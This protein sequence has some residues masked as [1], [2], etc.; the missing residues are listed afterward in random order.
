M[1]DADYIYAVACIR[2]KEKTLLTDADIQSMVGMK[3]EKE[4]LSYLTEKGWGDGSVGSDMETVLAT[5]EE[6]Q[7][8]LLRT[9]GVNSEIIDVLFIQELYHNL[10]AAIKEV[11]TGLDD[12]MA[13]Y[14]HDK[15]GKDQMLS[16]I[17][18]KDFE[19]LPEYMRKIAEEALDFMLTTRDGQR[20]DMM[21]DRACLDATIESAKLTKDRF[22][23]E[24]AETKVLMADIK[25]AVRTADTR[26]PLSVIEEALAPVGKLDTKK[27]AVAA[28]TNR[29]S[30]Y[31]FLER[32]GY[33]DAVEALK[34]SFS[35]FEKWC[36]D[37]VMGTLMNQ[38]T[39]IQSSGPIV[40]FFL[41]KQ[42]EIRTARIIM[43]AKANG[44]GEDVISERVR[45]MYG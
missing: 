20:L 28:A 4:V 3:S 29:D 33:H 5:E 18:D 44:F 15:Y 21:I 10:K 35:S 7:M 14:D 23:I 39:N 30:V 42:N 40:A 37:Y 6:A 41:A 9:L 45:K 43:T 36:D 8:R 31:E 1:R 27:L 24:Y 38:K 2:A 32:V 22:L 13:F 26:R 11:C 34:D 25:I 19:K 17:R 16:I 12:G